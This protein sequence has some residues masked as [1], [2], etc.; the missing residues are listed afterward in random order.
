MISFSSSEIREWISEFR[1]WD[2]QPP[3]LIPREESTFTSL[4]TPERGVLVWDLTSTPPKPAT[5]A[6]TATLCKY[7]LCPPINRVT[8][9]PPFLTNE[10]KGGGVWDWTLL[11]YTFFDDYFMVSF[12]C[13]CSLRHVGDLGN[14]L[15]SAQGVASTQFRDEVISLQGQGSIL[16]R[17]LVVRKS[18]FYF[19][20]WTIA[21]SSLRFSRQFL[22]IICFGTTVR[23]LG[24]RVDSSC[25]Y[26]GVHFIYKLIRY[27][28]H[29]SISWVALIIH[30]NWLY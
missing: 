28:I 18:R 13:C 24:I 16:G 29:L 15:Q 27:R 25:T 30:D 19:R 2:C 3:L 17:S 23:A 6:E 26:F 10:R 5:V 7:L 20:S 9:P 4:E 11:R 14:M 22:T 1:W 12:F 8:A 21:S